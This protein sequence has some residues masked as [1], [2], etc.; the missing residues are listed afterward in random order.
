MKNGGG[1][2][3]VGFGVCISVYSMYSDMIASLLIY[4]CP[5]HVCVCVLF[6]SFHKALKMR[7]VGLQSPALADMQKLKEYTQTYIHTLTP[8]TFHT[9]TKEPVSTMTSNIAVQSFDSQFA[10]LFDNMCLFEKG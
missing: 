2:R 4:N 6:K 8:P 5:L 7:E 9:H 10:H 3:R 1:L